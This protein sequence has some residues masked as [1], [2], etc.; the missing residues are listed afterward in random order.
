MKRFIFSKNKSLA[1]A[2]LSLFGIALLIGFQNCSKTNF[3]NGPVDGYEKFSV[4][5]TAHVPIVV[6][7]LNS[8]QNAIKLYNLKDCG[9][10]VVLADGSKMK[11]SE[12][13]RQQAL[14]EVANNPKLVPVQ[15][16]YSFGQKEDILAQKAHE[17]A[18]L[19]K[20][21]G[22]FKDEQ[23]KD[24]T[25]V[26]MA[27]K[28]SAGTN[29]Y[30]ADHSQAKAKYLAGDRC[31]YSTIEI[32]SD[33]IKEKSHESYSDFLKDVPKTHSSYTGGE[34]HHAVQ[35]MLGGY[36]GI[37]TGAD[38][39]S[40]YGAGKY[41]KDLYPNRLF[42]EVPSIQEYYEN[43]KASGKKER[44]F[45]KLYVADIRDT[46]FGLSTATSKIIKISELTQRGQESTMAVDDFIDV[47]TI[48]E[49]FATASNN[50]EKDFTSKETDLKFS[51]MDGTKQLIS[52]LC[53]ATLS[54]TTL[55]TQYTPIVVDLGTPLIRTSGI[56]DGVLFNMS[57]VAG[58]MVKTAWVG[59]H[60][61]KT[62]TISTAGIAFEKVETTEA[63][64]GFLVIPNADGSI[65]DAK[66]LFGSKMSVFGRTY[67]NGFEA[68]MVL[69]NKNC[70]STDIKS[71][72]LGPWDGALYES[73]I[74]VWVDKNRN[75]K[76]DAGE[77]ISLRE[78]GVAA[79]NTCYSNK[80]GSTDAYGNETAI[81]GMMIH[82]KPMIAT[83]QDIINAIITRRSLTP[84]SE[85]ISR[86]LAV[87]IIFKAEPK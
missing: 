65:T 37:G 70:R 42:S 69:A 75:G 30:K 51:G 82:Q 85:G 22:I 14:A 21:R 87:D 52:N 16:A 11:R 56:A 20:D 83:E 10:P 55:A 63:E 5:G 81:Q 71:Q 17:R 45:I 24:F 50:L 2:G 40:R 8:C 49:N 41:G 6:E 7:S 25:A 84:T 18:I 9:A 78:A 64:D 62:K 12:W 61:I 46:H 31:F 77:V 74:K 36:N 38:D 28:D 76:S 72:Y 26:I 43:G 33:L 79:I 29:Y 4:P 80:Y 19:S 54:L 35:H 48:I 23:G 3:S 86:R 60:V 53:A 67:Q 39:N 59:G 47:N 57:G 73:Q 68:L 34:A 32:K 44:Q 1:I 15:Y 13:E 27:P 58:E 66:N